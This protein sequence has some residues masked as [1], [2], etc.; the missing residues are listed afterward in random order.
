MYQADPPLHQVASSWNHSDNQT[1]NAVDNGPATQMDQLEA[2][3]FLPCN[4]RIR[5]YS[6]NDVY[7][8]YTDTS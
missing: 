6:L 4:W 3:Y 8:P 2:L 5:F 7:V 1:T